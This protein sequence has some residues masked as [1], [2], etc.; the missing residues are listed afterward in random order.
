MHYQL[1]RVC[2]CLIV[3]MALISFSASAQNN[4]LS[5]PEGGRYFEINEKPTFLYGINY[6]AALAVRFLEDQG[7]DGERG[8]FSDLDEMKDYIPGGQS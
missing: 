3:F 7:G 4:V 6:H 1:I 2:R 8:I 5:I